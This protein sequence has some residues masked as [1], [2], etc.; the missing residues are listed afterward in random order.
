MKATVWFFAA[1]AFS[2]APAGLDTFAAPMRTPPYS[3]CAAF[4]TLDSASGGAEYEAFARRRGNAA[5]F[6]DGLKS[7]AASVSLASRGSS[8]VV[9][10]RNPFF[11][12]APPPAH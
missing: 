5:P 7:E 8:G 9:I 4:I 1:L 2:A 6:V 12:A 10:V 3:P 11:E